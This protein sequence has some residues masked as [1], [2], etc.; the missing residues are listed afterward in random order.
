[1]RVGV[2]CKHKFHAVYRKHGFVCSGGR[3]QKLPKPK[4][5]VTTP[6]LPA[7]QPLPAGTTTLTLP[8]NDW[9]GVDVGKLALADSAVWTASGLW[10]IDPTTNAVSGPLTTS[11]QSENIGTGEG[12]VWASDFGHDLIRRYDAATGQLLAVIQLPA[13]SAPA[14]ITDANG[15]IWVADHHGGTVSRIDPVTNKVVANIK[16][17]TAGASGGPHGIAAGLGSVWVGVGTANSVVR[18]DPATNTIQA[19]IRMTGNVAEPCGGVAV[20]QTAV[21]I[22]SCLDLP[23][24]ARIDPATNKVASILNVGY[25]V[26]PVA[27]GDTVWFVTGG[28]PGLPPH[29]ASLIHLGADDSVKA[30]YALDTGFISGGTA[31]AFGSIWLSDWNKPLVLRIPTPH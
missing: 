18:I 8:T 11:D 28:D 15:A 25:V 1:L 27:D 10:R 3:L 19:M 14:G 9:P 23:M 20:G 30:R 2:S 13:G 26:D 22:T 12:S 5:L 6:K 24:V 17:G 31:L 29:S 4:P 21:W 7:A 16:V